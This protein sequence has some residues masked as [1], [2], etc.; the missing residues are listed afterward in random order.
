MN[1]KLSG[2][3]CN[4]IILIFARH[5]RTSYLHMDEGPY[6]SQNKILTFL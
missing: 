2:Y 5:N 6:H 3:N 4:E 1:L